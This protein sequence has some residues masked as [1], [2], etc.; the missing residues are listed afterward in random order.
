VRLVC[1]FL[2]HQLMVLLV[3]AM[4]FLIS[5]QLLLVVLVAMAVFSMSHSRGLWI[6]ALLV[7]AGSCPLLLLQ[8]AW[9]LRLK[10][11][12]LFLLRPLLLLFDAQLFFLLVPAVL[13]APLL[14]HP[15]LHLQQPD[16]VPLLQVLPGSCQGTSLNLLQLHLSPFLLMPHLSPSLHQCIHLLYPLLQL[17]LEMGASCVLLLLFPQFA[18]LLEQACNLLARGL[19]LNQLPPGSFLCLILPELQPL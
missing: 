17:V 2:F 3:L 16:L 11:V 5:G 6:L 1:P 8:V 13:L 18:L 14:A 7:L 9:L 10:V 19:L 12:C 15:C 4:L